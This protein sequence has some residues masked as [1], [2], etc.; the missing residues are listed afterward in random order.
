MELS[1]FIPGLPAAAASCYFGFAGFAMESRGNFD[2]AQL[3]Y[4][5]HPDGHDLT[6]D[7]AGSW[8]DSWYVVG[9][10]TVV[11]DPFFVDLNAENLPVYTAMHGTGSWEP[12]LV[13]SSLAGFMSALAY[14]QGKSGQDADLVEPDENTIS[15]KK[16]LKK[17]YRHLIS[18]CGEEASFFWECF[19]EQHQDWLAESEE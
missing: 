2:K 6:G 15:D 17:I 16:E 1:K 9:R 7:S 5:T 11:G 19:I 14:L 3:G 18:L 8:K 13:S 12:S 10:D 4:R